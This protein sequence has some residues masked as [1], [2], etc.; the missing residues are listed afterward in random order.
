MNKKI[1]FIVLFSMCFIK[2]RKYEKIEPNFRIEYYLDSIKNNDSLKIDN[3]LIR[4]SVNKN[5]KNNLIEQI[6]KGLFNDFPLLLTKV[7]ECDGKYYLEFENYYISNKYKNSL[8]TF[9]INEMKV[10]FIGVVSKEIAFSLVENKLY[11]VDFDFIAYLNLD[12]SKKYCK[13][14]LWSPFIGVEKDY[15]KYANV[16]FGEIAIKIKSLKNYN[17]SL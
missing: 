3:T 16:E 2:C 6:N 15:G 14:F 9:N 8:N 12:N 11:L 13:S 5:F 1:L 17:E 4:K 7:K 10:G